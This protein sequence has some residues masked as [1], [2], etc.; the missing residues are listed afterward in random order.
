L[1]TPETIEQAQRHAERKYTISSKKIVEAS[2]QRLEADKH[3]QAAIGS[4]LSSGMWRLVAK[5]FAERL[6]SLL[7]AR[8]TALL[9]AYELYRVPLSNEIERQIIQDIPES[10]VKM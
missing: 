2:E 7:H 9:D 8:L 10:G 1:V 3:R 5:N 6:E 4:V